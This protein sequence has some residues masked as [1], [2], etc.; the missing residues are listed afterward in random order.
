M[1]KSNGT[2]GKLIFGKRKNNIGTKASYQG[3]QT[4]DKAKKQCRKY[5]PPKAENH[6]EYIKQAP[7]RFVRFL[8]APEL[9]FCRRI[10]IFSLCHGISF[11]K[12]SNIVIITPFNLLTTAV[13]SGIIS[14]KF[15][16][17][18]ANSP[19]KAFALPRLFICGCGG[20]GRRA[21]FRS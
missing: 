7:N 3:T 5:K 10:P 12:L 6:L 17:R 9:L 8:A 19:V 1:K 20:I 2:P 21:R 15:L 14:E 18:R 13:K 4:A 11:A 16:G